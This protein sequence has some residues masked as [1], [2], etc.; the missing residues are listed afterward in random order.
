MSVL[1]GALHTERE[2]GVRTWIRAGR[3]S[4]AVQEHRAILA[5]VEAR[6]PERAGRAILRHM[7]SCR[8]DVR[9][10]LFHQL[11]AKACAVDSPAGMSPELPADGPRITGR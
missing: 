7:P 2:L 11:E 9:G 5:T 8:A 3:R 1:S 10:Y 4:K 6:D